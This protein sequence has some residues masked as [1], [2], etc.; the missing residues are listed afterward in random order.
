MLY[1]A[2]HN[3]GLGAAVVRGTERSQEASL[4]R[5]SRSD[6]A[7]SDGT[8]DGSYPMVSLLRGSDGNLYGMTSSG[9]AESKGTV[10]DF[11]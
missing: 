2:G 9:G 1:A 7:P 10:F 5:C 11:N 3:I 6:A 4:P 8:A